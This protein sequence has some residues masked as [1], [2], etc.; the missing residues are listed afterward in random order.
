M[1]KLPTKLAMVAHRHLILTSLLGTGLRVVVKIARDC[2]RKSVP[3]PRG[4]LLDAALIEVSN[5]CSS[6]GICSNTL[7]VPMNLPASRKKQNMAE[8]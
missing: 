7:P 8:L 4:L 3:E 2:P 1:S 6:A 5:V